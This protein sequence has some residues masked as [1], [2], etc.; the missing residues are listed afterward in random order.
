MNLNEYYGSM[1]T[2]RL[3]SNRL[4]EST[5]DNSNINLERLKIILDKDQIISNILQPIKNNV[6]DYKAQKFIDNYWSSKYKLKIP[7]EELDHLK[8]IYDYIT[9]IVNE[10]KSFMNIC[11]DFKRSFSNEACRSFIDEAFK[12]LCDYIYSKL[13]IKIKE[14]ERNE[15]KMENKDSGIV[16]NY[17]VFQQINKV[18][19]DAIA[20]GR[21][22]TNTKTIT[23]DVKLNIEE[24]ISAIKSLLEK[25]EAIDNDVKENITDDIDII[26]EQLNNKNEPKLPRIKKALAN[27][28]TTISKGLIVSLPIISNLDKF[29]EAIQK[30]FGF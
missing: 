3:I 10:K 25:E 2:F 13:S 16:N 24:I 21:D 1:E 6:F 15:S 14:I 19:G 23:N 20:S 12:P 27:I 18:N 7:V 17:G 8:A 9:D 11:M 28:T 29:K 30:L 26:S 5:L 4:S 22:T